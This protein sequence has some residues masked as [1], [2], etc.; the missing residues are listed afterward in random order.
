MKM[1][2]WGGTAADGR[3]PADVMTVPPGLAASALSSA[4]PPFAAIDSAPGLARGHVKAALAEWGL[5]GLT[6]AAALI[7]SELVSNAVEAS[8]KV[9]LAVGVP[10]IRVC[11]F[12]DG[13]VLTVECW[14]QAPGVPVLC[15]VPELVERGRGLIIINDLTGGAWGYKPTIGQPGKCVWA[16]MPL[17]DPYAR[18]LPAAAAAISP[19]DSASPRREGDPLSA[20][21]WTGPW[22]T[23]L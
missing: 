12:T 16:M 14:D 19:P 3:R 23:P 13:G 18:R 4:T 20:R 8:A 15:V 9:P 7:A 17:R 6:D 10:L 21:G 2:S 22:C 1:Q 11:L 5:G